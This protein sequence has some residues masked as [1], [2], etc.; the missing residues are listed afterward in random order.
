M[1]VYNSDSEQ[2]SNAIESIL[3][4]T[5]QNFEF[6]ICN[7]CSSKLEVMEVLSKYKSIDSR[8][9]LI[10]NP[11]NSGLAASLNHCL[12][13]AK[14]EYI[15]RMDDDDISH[16]DRFEKQVAFLDEHLEFAIIGCAI[17]IFQN[18]EIWGYTINKEVPQVTDFLFSTPFTHPTV[19]I[20]RNALLDVDGYGVEKITKRTEDYDLFMRMYDKGY[21]GYNLQE[22]LFDYR[23]DRNGYKKQKF[24]YRLDEAVVRYRGFKKLGLLPKGTLYILKPILSGIVPISIK[25]WIHKNRYN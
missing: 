11:Q 1:G 20:R 18:D 25:K 7:D 24:K 9:K 22:V 15:A 16:L 6:I 14:G 10:S 13:Y 5:F 19:M 4:Q 8:I 23:M 3:N 2:L 21:L 12:K 17:N